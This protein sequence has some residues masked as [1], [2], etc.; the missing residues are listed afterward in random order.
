MPAVEKEQAEQKEER[1]EK[2]AKGGSSVDK[3]EKI[4]EKRKAKLAADVQ[5]P[6]RPTV[7][8]RREEPVVTASIPTVGVYDPKEAAKLMDQLKKEQARLANILTTLLS[9][10]EEER[11]KSAILDDRLNSLLKKDEKQDSLLSAVDTKLTQILERE[12][13]EQERVERLSQLRRL[14]EDELTDS[15]S[16]LS[17]IYEMTQKKLAVAREDM[18]LVKE[19]LKGLLDAQKVEEEKKLVG[20]TRTHEL[21]QQR[22]EALDDLT[23]LKDPSEKEK[24]LVLML[25]KGREELERELEGEIAGDPV[26]L[27]ALLRRE[28]AKGAL[29]AGA[30]AAKPITCPVCH[31]KFDVTSNERPLKIQCP[32]CGAVG[33]LKK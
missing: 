6:E 25:K 20:L 31:T 12:R 15:L 21:T 9:D 1:S 28:K 4:L 7:P 23:K 3:F 26:K 17:E 24:S 11:K 5:A 27:A 30:A 18:A 16:E 22:L 8:E 13:G 33:I 29:P 32:S 2:D 10:F 14:E 19:K